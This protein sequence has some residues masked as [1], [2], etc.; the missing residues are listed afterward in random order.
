MWP[1][2]QLSAETPK[3]FEQ[4][5][6]HY[7][8]GDAAPESGQQT[9]QLLWRAVSSPHIIYPAEDSENYE[10]AADTAAATDIR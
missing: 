7:S 8:A 3:A 4:A 6:G 5:S 1:W 10:F 2:R 9:L